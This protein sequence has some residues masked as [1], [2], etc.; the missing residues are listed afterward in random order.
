MGPF[1]IDPVIWAVLRLVI[2]VG[3][4]VFLVLNGALA[5]IFLERKIQ[6]VMQDRI[7]PYHTGPFGLLQ[8]FADA[9][10][11]IGKEDIR[12]RLTDAPF[13]LAAPAIVFSPMLASFVVLPF[14]PD[15]VG[16][17]LNV[18]LLY[19]TTLG[20]MTVLGIVIAGWAS[21][22][23]YS[24]MGG[25]RSAGQLISYE[26]PQILALVTVVL[27]VGSLSMVD[28]TNSQ[29]GP[30]VNVLILPMAFVTYLI[31]ALAE[32]NRNPF[33]LPEAESELVAGFLTEYSGMRWGVFFVAEYGEVTV[34]SAI[35]ATLWFGGWHGP[36]VDALPILGVLWFTLKTYMFVL[37]FMWIRATL[38]RLRIDQL[39]GFCWK[40][41]IPLALVNIMA[42]AV[43]ILA[44]ADPRLPLAIVNWIL[45]AALVFGLPFTQR[46]RLLRFRARTKEHV[47]MRDVRLA[48]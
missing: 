13:F 5:Q 28:I 10:K 16:A 19:L 34:V 46:R 17:N 7:G 22:N 47:A 9:I 1:G 21:N 24:L 6:A 40:V 29:P 11:L 38:P 33:D 20:S 4:A 43:L 27:Y 2:A 45:V 15:F 8:T 39:M 18:G 31:A 23:K 30:L 3:L 41:L 25:L 32:T 37:L 42:T 26:V 14:G 12:A 48:P 36:G 44:F 35:M